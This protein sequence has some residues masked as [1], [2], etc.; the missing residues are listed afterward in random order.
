MRRERLCV[1]A[2]DRPQNRRM[3]MLVMMGQNWTPHHS[4]VTTRRACGCRGIDDMR[5]SRWAA[6][7]TDAG[8]PAASLAALALLRS[9][10]RA[11]GPLSE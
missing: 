5:M 9:R 7:S 11:S 8:R 2:H 10:E 1:F 6:S 4:H 3:L